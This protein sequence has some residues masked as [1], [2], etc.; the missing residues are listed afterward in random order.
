M[1]GNNQAPTELLVLGSTTGNFV[2]LASQ[3]GMSGRSLEVGKHRDDDGT[4]E[5]TNAQPPVVFFLVSTIRGRLWA[6]FKLQARSALWSLL[7]TLETFF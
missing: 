7:Q 2:A 6:F 3:R 1:P 5:T 4:V